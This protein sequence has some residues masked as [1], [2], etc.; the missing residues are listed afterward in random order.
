MAGTPPRSEWLEKVHFGQFVTRQWLLGRGVSLH[1]LDNAL[2]SGKLEALA[3]GVVARPGVAITWEAA[4]ASLDRLLPEPVYVGGLSA[5]AEAGLGH[6]LDVS[7]SL[8]L[9]SPARAPAWLGKLPLQTRFVWHNTARLWDMQALLAADSLRRHSLSKNT[10]WMMAS[11]EQAFMEVLSGV[12][13]VVSFE[14]ADNLMQGMS[15]LSPRRLD[16]LLRASRHIQVKRLFF[17]FADRYG[18]AWRKRL[19]PEHYDL[20]SGKRSI[21]AGGKLDRTYLITVPRSFHGSE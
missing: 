21:V 14:H 7:E 9:Y 2:K 3:R 15:A 5:L 6:Y 13:N 17:F 18:Y 11:P 12:P 8:H 10:G 16:V 19:D 1:A 4:V 20:G